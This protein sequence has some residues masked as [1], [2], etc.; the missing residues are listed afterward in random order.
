MVDTRYYLIFL[1]LFCFCT[2]FYTHFSAIN[3]TFLSLREYIEA[4]LAYQQRQTH[5]E[6]EGSTTAIQ[7]CGTPNYAFQPHADIRRKNFTL[8]CPHTVIYYSMSTFGSGVGDQLKSLYHNLRIAYELNTTYIY[9]PLRGR[10]RHFEPFL[11][12]FHG[13]LDE[14]QLPFYYNL[15][16]KKCRLFPL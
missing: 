13:E 12:L 10:A 9:S 2:V 1:L 16:S 8:R 7:K 3:G 11:R 4:R 14:N 15:H 5:S 6:L